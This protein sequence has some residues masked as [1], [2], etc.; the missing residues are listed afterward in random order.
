MTTTRYR[1]L[2][3][4]YQVVVVVVVVVVKDNDQQADGQTRVDR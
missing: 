2:Q 1:N 3:Y 4:A